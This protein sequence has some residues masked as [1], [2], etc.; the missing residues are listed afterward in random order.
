MNVNKIKIG[1]RGSR[2][3]LIQTNLVIGALQQ[4]YPEIECE[5]VI[6]HTTGDKILDKPLLEFGGKGVF[7]TE[8]EEAILRDEIDFA[9]HS[10]KD[11]PMELLDGLE[12][13]GV[14]KREDP[15]DV[16]ITRQ[17]T[18][19]DEIEL[20][21]IGTS[22]LRRQVQ[23]EQIYNNVKCC[24]LRGNVDTRLRKLAEGNYDGIIL[25]AAGIKRLGLDEELDFQYR[26]LEVDELI[27]AGGQGIIAIEGKRNGKLNELWNNISDSKAKMELA[28]ERRALELFS[29]GCNEPIGVYAK[30]YEDMVTIRMMKMMNGKIVK[31]V[32]STTLEKRWELLESMVNHILED[33]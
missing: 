32:E 15:R 24:S 30:V 20:P 28:M 14:L 21:V 1:T 13:I 2:L 7:V 29:A 4:K 33:F 11:M 22:S 23:I 18:K 12:I 8:F 25:A 31:R 9:V 19:L 27:P 6:I 17:S 10:A 26:Y 5:I 3:A 16:L